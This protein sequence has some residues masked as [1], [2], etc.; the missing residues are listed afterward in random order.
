MHSGTHIKEHLEG[1]L[2]LAISLDGNNGIY[3]LAMGIVNK[4][5]F[6]NWSWF[7][8]LLWEHVGID[9]QRIVTFMLNRYKGFDTAWI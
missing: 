1:T 4:E 5:N 3:P 2:L 6:D 9:D 8:Q 7:L